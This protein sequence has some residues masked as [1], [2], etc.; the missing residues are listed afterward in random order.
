MGHPA[1]ELVTEL[2]PKDAEQV[3]RV[4]AVLRRIPSRPALI[5]RTYAELR[6]AL[7]GT[8]TFLATLNVLTGT[9]IGAAVEHGVGADMEVAVREA[10]RALRVQRMM[11]VLTIRDT[12]LRDE[13][14]DIVAEAR[15]TLATMADERA[16]DL[17]PE[18]RRRL[19]EPARDPAALDAWL[20]G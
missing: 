20:N 18:E 8:D 12:D 15:E 16:A 19:G 17:E 13:D 9:L 7:S 6:E 4:M 11:L 14:E 3:R 1:E 2:A 5:G 10:C